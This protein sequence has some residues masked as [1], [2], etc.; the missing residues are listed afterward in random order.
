MIGH[1]IKRSKSMRCYICDREISSSHKTDICSVCRQAIDD[2]KRDSYEDVAEE[3]LDLMLPRMSSLEFLRF[4]D[5]KCKK[6]K[7]K[8]G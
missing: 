4:I 1:F 3:D 5:S 6:K 2:C 7:K 8:N